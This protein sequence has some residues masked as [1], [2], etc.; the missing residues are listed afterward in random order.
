MIQIF[1]L[2]QLGV[3][4]STQAAVQRGDLSVLSDWDPDDWGS[5]IQW[6]ADRVY[7]PYK[8]K[9]LGDQPIGATVHRWIAE[10]AAANLL[11]EMAPPDQSEMCFWDTAG[12]LVLPSDPDQCAKLLPAFS[13]LMGDV[14]KNAAVFAVW[15]EVRQAI[16]ARAPAAKI[17]PI[18][19]NQLNRLRRAMASED[20]ALWNETWSMRSSRWN[21]S[22]HR[23]EEAWLS[24]VEDIKKKNADVIAPWYAAMAAHCPPL[25]WWDAVA[26]LPTAP[27]LLAALAATPSTQFSIKAPNEHIPVGALITSLKSLKTFPAPPEEKGHAQEPAQRV[28]AWLRTRPEMCREFLSVKLPIGQSAPYRRDNRNRLV[29]RLTHYLLPDGSWR[30]VLSYG[31]LAP[32]VKDWQPLL[33]TLAAASPSIRTEVASVMLHGTQSAAAWVQWADAGLIGALSAEMPEALGDKWEVVA[34]DKQWANWAAAEPLPW[35]D[36][37]PRGVREDLPMTVTAR[38]VRAATQAS[39]AASLSLSLRRPQ[40]P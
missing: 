35:F 11:Q 34:L 8:S 6:I 14:E 31:P 29:D 30:G 18:V 9:T 7:L 39:H 40:Q 36:Q 4:Q 16:A 17:K 22:T 28:V 5:V 23:E 25:L 19:I 26:H 37:L 13:K 32:L 15:T 12:R 24:L 3:T 1:D 10:A 38:R 27:H 33:A 20:L 21:L 2:R